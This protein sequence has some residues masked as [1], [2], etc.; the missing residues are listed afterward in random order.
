MKIGKYLKI[1]ITVV[2]MA[3][4][5][6][7]WAACSEK[8]LKI[9]PYYAEYGKPFSVPVFDG[10]TTVKDAEGYS[11]D[12]SSGR[13]YVD[14]TENYAI[15]VK[16]GGKTYSGE[17]IVITDEIPV[18]SLSFDIKYG[19]VNTPV[20][21]PEVSAYVGDR[22]VSASMSMKKGE[23]EIDISEGFTP[24]E[25]GEYTLTVTAVSGDKTSQRVVPYY[26][27]ET[28]AFADKIASFDK[29]YGVKHVK[30]YYGISASYSTEMKHGDEAGSTKVTISTAEAEHEAQF[31]FGNFH[32]KDWTGLTGLRMYV[33]NDNSAPVSMC[34]NWSNSKQLLP[35]VWTQIYIPRAD[36]EKLDDQTNILGQFRLDAADGINAEV[37]APISGKG[38]FSL[39]FSGFYAGEK[40]VVSP[41]EIS[42]KIARFNA[43]EEAD[44]ELKEEIE[45]NYAELSAE[46]Q[47][48][49]AG[50]AD[51]RAKCLAF[52]RAEGAEE[53]VFAATDAEYGQYQLKR[54]NC[55]TSFSSGMRYGDDAGSTLI[56]T[57]GFYTQI[58]VE[59][60]HF[61]D[62]SDIEYLEYY[63]YNA[64]QKD[65]AVQLYYPRT[66]TE[67][68]PAGEWTRI[69]VDTSLL[70][71]A[72]DIY[73][74]TQIYSGNWSQGLEK[75]NAKFYMSS[76]KAVKP[77]ITT[78]QDLY[79]H[80]ADLRE[81]GSTD[82]EA[83]SVIRW[84]NMLSDEEKALV[85]NFDVFVKEY[86]LKRDGVDT[87]LENRLT[88]FDS[89]YG[90][91]Q[92]VS[93]GDSC[94]TAYTTSM[95]YGNEK[96][97]VLVTATNQWRVYVGLQNLEEVDFSQYAY[98]EF[99]IYVENTW[100]YP[101]ILGASRYNE[102][103]EEIV[104]EANRWNQVKLPL[105][106]DRLLATD[107]L[108][109]CGKDGNTGLDSSNYKFY[110]SSVFA[111][112]EGETKAD[113]VN[114]TIEAL[115]NGTPT[116]AEVLALIESYEALGA[117]DKAEVVGYDEFLRD[118]YL[119]RDN[120]PTDAADRITYFDSE[121]G[122]QQIE[123][124]GSSAT[125]AYE[126]AV[127]YGDEAG[128][129][130]VSGKSGTGSSWRIY[131]G[132]L[133]TEAADMRKYE[134]I[135]FYI[136]V[137]NGLS[138]NDIEVAGGSR[139]GFNAGGAAV[140]LE[141]NA[142]TKVRLPVPADGVVTDTDM[143]CLQRK[144]SD[145]HGLDSENYVFYISAIYGVPY[146]MDGETLKA[147]IDE[148]MEGTITQSDVDGVKLS[149]SLLS[150]EEQEKVTN[151]KPFLKGFY[152]VRD[153]VPTDA[154]GRV[155]YFDSEYG[156]EQV[157][158]EGGQ[159]VVYA[160][161][162]KYGD[163]KGSL[164]V[165]G[166]AGA[167]NIH[168]RLSETEMSEFGEYTSVRFYIMAE[169]PYADCLLNIGL[170]EANLN[171]GSAVLLTRGEWTEIVLPVPAGGLVGKKLVLTHKDETNHG[172]N[173]GEYKFYISA[174]YAMEDT[175][176]T[177]ESLKAQIDELIAGGAI[178]EEDFN[179]VNALYAALTEAE[180]QAVTN[181]KQF[182]KTYYV[183]R[184]G[185]PAGEANRL[186]YFDSEYG[187]YQI[188]AKKNGDGK[189]YC[190]ASYSTDRAYGDEKGSIMFTCTDQWNV[191]V[192]LT[193]VEN[194][195]FAAYDYIEFYIYVENSHNYPMRI[196]ANRYNEGGEEIV[197]QPNEWNH[198]LLPL[199]EDRLLAQ[200]FF[201]FL[202]KDG[203]TGLD[204]S[205]YKFY[206][207]AIYARTQEEIVTA[208]AVNAMIE[209]LKGGAPTDEDVDKLIAAYE[210][211][212][213]EEQEKVTGY[214]A[215]LKDYYLERD[216]ADTARENR[217]TYFDSEYG[218]R[219]IVPRGNSC[220]AAY[221]T[222]RSFG[223]QSG[224]IV[225]TCGPTWNVYVGLTGIEDVDLAAYDFIEFYIYVENSYNYAMRIGASRYNEGGAEIVLQPNKWNLVRLPM[226][227]D[228]LLD[229]D[230]LQ[231]LGKDGG[232]GLNNETYKF[233]I[234][235]VFAVKGD[236]SKT[237]EINETIAAYAA[238]SPTDGEV[239]DLIAAYDALTAEEQA[240]ITGYTEFIKN[241]YL[242]R[243]GVPVDKANR[244]TYFDSEY[245]LS[246][247][248]P[249]GN[250]C[251]AA[252]TADRAYGDEKGSIAFTCTNQWNVYVGL[253]GI[254]EVDLAAYDFIEFYIY[255]E[256]DYD[257]AMRIGASR[258]N[259]GG[260]EI[261]LQPNEWNHVKLPLYEDK[262]L[263]TD[264]LQFLGKD[265]ATG[266]DSPVY[267][268]YISAIYATTAESA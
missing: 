100:N 139:G 155:T 81:N 27:E 125:L 102:G 220:T 39:Y 52:I 250:S 41:A 230:F 244:L 234:S 189:P 42:K 190:V 144:D 49:V 151:Y 76:V 264:F 112:K 186:T 103:G 64:N 82:E 191:Y 154:E 30:N 128:S 141:L 196:G 37:M 101:V 110:I 229:T 218:L 84:Y 205:A 173:S 228:S 267:K 108:Q 63:L 183:A 206:F 83:E 123:V 207:S 243:D 126:K 180:K 209:D 215:F 168:L 161:D 254:E 242:E 10:E 255:V 16:S 51:F 98:I 65:Y 12:I 54:Y 248:V 153:G 29:P 26:I 233:Y 121:Y 247:I 18:I 124:R 146:D 152:T 104:L 70:D 127:A 203:G 184:D 132:L 135:E 235:S 72:D 25:T 115:K 195:D 11:V 263:A 156:T 62:L 227:A 172:V 165:T 241:Y 164:L 163:E 239:K 3:L 136:Y 99:Y 212:S 43:L 253:T 19:K 159:P 31:A 122:L 157:V 67:T 256:N 147:Q 224:S 160:T 74:F 14:S 80:I 106:E 134:Y 7:T 22:A 33:Y 222:A 24:A 252:Y 140:P 174:I 176:V 238:G 137:S 95:A 208:D 117:I 87:T 240:Q 148:L 88:Y 44:Y 79:D 97:S 177:G 77:L 5:A 45:K 36:M 210:S 46:Q 261:V 113:I 90:L 13:F 107:F 266:L 202:G 17:I 61:D 105:Y 145:N 219:Q 169:N 194:I 259:E 32:I 262:L 55:M 181:Y 182:L 232:T 58:D 59:Y 1:A 94:T 120:V 200:D 260:A 21:L 71:S 68:L 66:H 197:L 226:K 138:I 109:L 188:E 96:G 56:Q 2:I 187:L 60:P 185:V 9:G 57:Y 20:A 114:A 6:A 193:E 198:I 225:F 268:F 129:I 78:G 38:T 249:R 85:T 236:I 175:G 143:L 221:T 237:Q 258:Y 86:Y 251:T 75:D 40:D 216:G 167:W 179:A 73:Y 178:S 93:R 50:Y 213:A 166:K 217:L 4:L 170:D 214:E 53:G 48:E 15:E 150:A 28:D 245:G 119:T 118:Y 231:L 69:L 133:K 34:L 111:L 201:Q 47:A 162:K 23:T 116:D 265:G 130:R 192:G 35:G 223:S 8:D 211:L 199:Y 91:Q 204:S 171:T 158:A 142:W 89:E 149:Y 257:Y 131:L 92:I 246:Q